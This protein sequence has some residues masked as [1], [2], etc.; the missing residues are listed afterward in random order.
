[1]ELLGNLEHDSGVECNH[2]CQKHC[3]Q[4]A[5]KVIDSPNLFVYGSL[6]PGE[7]AHEQIVNFLESSEEATLPGYQ[8][9]I[10]DGLPV[11]GEEKHVIDLAGVLLTISPKHLQD[12]WNVVEDI[13]G[14][15]N[16]KRLDNVDFTSQ[17]RKI[18]G[19]VYVGRKMHRGNAEPLVGPWTTRFDPIFSISF[20]ILHNEIA[21]MESSFIDPD[22]NSDHYWTQMN[23]LL[24]R[25]LLLVSILEH[26]TVIRFGGSKRQEPM[27]RL[28]KFQESEAFQDAFDNVFSMGLIPE[29]TVSDSRDVSA[30]YT[31]SNAGEAVDAWYQVRSNL[32][33]RGKSVNDARL[34]HKAC[35]GLSNLLMEYL[36]VEVI[37]IEDEWIRNLR[38]PISFIRVLR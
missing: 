22:R 37:G 9:Y 6:K 32:Q 2:K 34:V 38:L 11:I 3:V 13:E 29:F 25:Y 16:Y 26:L 4:K 10:R 20:P 28:K 14:D 8:L 36:R 23:E 12:F 24:S 5:M 19:S 21:K 33:H 18:S 27:M 17:G 30:T 15:K 31:T 1:M 35:I 7:L